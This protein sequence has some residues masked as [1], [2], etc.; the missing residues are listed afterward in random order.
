MKPVLD[1]PILIPL[2]ILIIGL[3]IYAS[4][5]SSHHASS[6]IRKLL[7]VLR[8]LALIALCAFL[9]NPGKWVETVQTKPRLY[10]VLIDESASMATINLQTKLTRSDKAQLL[11]GEINKAA[12]ENSIT[13]ELYG[14]AE[15]SRKLN[16]LT[17]LKA[18]G[19]N[20]N[21]HRSGTN[22]FTKLQSGGDSPEAL[23]VLTDGRQ[24]LAP[25]N[26][27]L[28][29]L[30]RAN[31]APIYAISIG[32][33]VRKSDLSLKSSRNT[34][35]AFPGQNI[36]I[37]AVIENQHLG[38]QSVNLTLTDN[39]GKELANQQLEIKNNEK[40]LHTFSVKAPEKTAILHLK[41]GKAA[42]EQIASNNADQ[43]NIRIL[44]TKTR[45]FIA[46]AAPYWDSKFLAQLLRQQGHMDVHSVHRLS[47]TRWFRIDSDQSEPVASSDAIFPDT[48]EA[49]SHYD[50]IIF[51][52]NAEHFLTEQR[53]EALKS[54]VRDQGGAILFA[55][56]K[57]YSGRV[58]ALETLEPVNW[59][60]GNTSEFNIAPTADGQNAGLFGQALPEPNSPIWQS[61]PS[62][63]DAHRVDSVKPFTRI[64]AEGSLPSNKGKFPLLMV[65]RYGQGVTGLVNADGLWKWD[66][67]PEARE[68]GNM[69]QEFWTQMIQWMV[70]YSEFLP[71]H[72]Y[73]IH[74]SSQT[75]DLQE[76]VSFSISYRGTKKSP[77]PTVTITAEGKEPIQ[78]NPASSVPVA[79]KPT[80]KCSFEP[81]E[82]GRYTVT[83]NTD[84]KSPAPVLNIQVKAPPTE[85]DNLN[86]DPVF[87]SELCESTG[88]R[89]ID[90]SELTTFLNEMFSQKSH[91]E[92]KSESIWKSSW[93]LWF[94][95]IIILFILATEWWVRRRSG[96]I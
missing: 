89:V 2:I 57:P 49:L 64:L 35:T 9:L 76:P 28:S 25:K 88:G 66:F 62:L 37:T 20:S 71:G 13:T 96:L 40:K 26:S 93:L 91:H 1:L 11:T 63:K 81:S 69:Y 52:K 23:I 29:L 4:W 6:G 34:I 58:E 70:A 53:I 19:N 24:T 15:D 60:S 50:L 56:G 38:N 32:K 65:R 30:S 22:L 80:W 45:V 12:E 94:V 36:Q 67:Y 17:D 75:V 92:A 83:L 95:P 82:P 68:L 87:L 61:L 18:D 73:S 46:E 72:D 54:F 10:P 41:I 39:A 78:L 48:K 47:E 7:I 44:K 59:A 5:R 55:R 31:N 85:Q 77:K 33:D 27:T 8:T 90:E 16:E 84:D 51:G 3:G 42:G 74:T 86:P 79:G 14:F 21:L 43:I